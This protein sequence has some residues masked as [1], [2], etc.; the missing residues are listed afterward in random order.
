MR[1]RPGRHRNGLVVGRR[2]E[3]TEAGRLVCR[4]IRFSGWYAGLLVLTSLVGTTAELL[5]PAALGRAVDAVL[6]R[7]AAP[8]WLALVGILVAVAAA[9]DTLG[10]LAD[11]LGTARATARLRG[12]LLRHI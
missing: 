1:T 10:E 12:T 2:R 7:A 8:R 5:L 3:V 11:G 4:A 9:A 6:D